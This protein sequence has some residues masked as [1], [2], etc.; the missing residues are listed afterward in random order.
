MRS[1]LRSLALAG[2]TLLALGAVPDVTAQPRAA[3]D[4]PAPL[5]VTEAW[6][7]RRLPQPDLVVVHVAF[8]KAEYDAGHIPGARFI[9]FAGYAVTSADS[10]RTELPPRDS[11]AR[12]FGRAGISNTS[13]VIIVGAPIPATRF[14]LTLAA[15]GLDARASVLDGGIEAWREAMRPMT[16]E[17][18]AVGVTVPTLTDAT[19][20]LATAAEVRGIVGSGGAQL[21]DARLPE[22]FT[23]VANNGFPRAGR[24]QGAANV[25]FN[26]LTRELGRLRDPKTIDRLLA[27]AGAA[28]GTPVVTYCHVGQQ[29]SLLWFAARLAGRE[30]RVY[31]GSF[32]EWSRLTDAPVSTGPAR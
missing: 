23:G 3:D 12:V 24:I 28:K 30:A 27:A 14:L 20:V 22:F 29:A 19:R 10:L 21:L 31:D 15:T 32:Q 11:L 25:P 16:T 8:D 26:T 5:L 6:L 4:P 1:H 17:V 9:P 7:A 2:A 13:R 18:P